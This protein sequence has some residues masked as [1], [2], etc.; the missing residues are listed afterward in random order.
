MR[1]LKA[2]G[3]SKGD[4]AP[5]VATLLTL[6]QQLAQAQGAPAAEPSAGS[7]K[8]KAGQQQPIPSTN[9]APATA[10]QAEVGRLQALVTEQASLFLWKTQVPEPI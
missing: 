7:K 3:A 10:D 1:S 6:K 2:G 8:K 5:E 9:G 4:V